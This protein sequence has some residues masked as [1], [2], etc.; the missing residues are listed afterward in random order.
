[1][2][3]RIGAG[4]DPAYSHGP[5]SPGP[6]PAPS[7]AGT[8]RDVDERE[9]R[10]LLRRRLSRTELIL[11]DVA[12]ALAYTV[13]VVLPAFGPSPPG[14]VWA[15]CLV[16]AGAGLPVALRRLFPLPVFVLVCTVSVV[17][18][19]LGLLGD[20][21]LAAAFAVYPVAVARPRRRREP[22]VVIGVLSGLLVLVAVVS[23]PATAGGPGILVAGCALLGCSW[24]IGRAVRER[25][26]ASAVAAERLAERA[27]AEERLRIARELHD[28]VSHTLSLIGVKAAVA[29]HVADSRPDEVRDALRVIESTSGQ[30]LTEMRHMLGLLRSPESPDEPRPVP[31]LAGLDAL[32]AGATDA[33]VTVETTVRGTDGLPGDVARAVYR[34]VQEAVTNV[35]R[36][37]APAR[38]TVLVA[39]TADGVR[40]EVAD[41]GTRPVRTGHRPG[42]GLLGMRERVAM[43]GGTMTA[44]P[45][46]GGGFTVTAHLPVPAAEGAR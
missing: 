25:R 9:P 24:T 33:G 27:A 40:V 44:G 22:T 31:G 5:S 26:A 6:I 12:A 13:V 29:N 16:A 3:G 35:V 11:L 39:A 18:A 20:P 1:M 43:H 32:A 2:A 45:R 37:A 46:P 14:P 23:G 36:H 19:G 28:V 10:S 41:D 15:V 34:I 21:L 38:C 30:A 8:F 42:H 4:D 7:P 17:G